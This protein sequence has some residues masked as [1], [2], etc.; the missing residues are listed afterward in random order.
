MHAYSSSEVKG[1]SHATVNTTSGRTELAGSIEV[2][3][4]NCYLSTLASAEIN[5]KSGSNDF[6][7]ALQTTVDR[8]TEKVNDTVIETLDALEAYF[9]DSYNWDDYLKLVYNNYKQDNDLD[10]TDLLPPNVN[11]SSFDD[12]LAAA[13]PDTTITFRFDDLDLY[14]ELE[15]ILNAS[16]TYTLKLIPPGAN[17]LGLDLPNNIK[18]GVVFSADLIVSIDSELDMTGGLHVKVDDHVAMQLELFGD[19]VS[20]MTL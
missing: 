16:A 6:S 18:F 3:C 14:L 10:I 13:I 9:R 8:V 19:K 1:P 4:K 20:D 5:I 15:T 2:R 7:T 11:V 12:D 17:P